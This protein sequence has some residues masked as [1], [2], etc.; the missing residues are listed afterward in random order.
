MSNPALD[1]INAH[2]DPAKSV[3]LNIRQWIFEQ[4]EYDQLPKIEETL[5]W[6]EPSY[7]VKGGSTIRIDFKQKNP[8]HVVIYLNCK[9]T[10]I[11]T[12]REVYSTEFKFEGNRAL[13]INLNTAIPEA[14]IK[15]CLSM[16][17]NY[18]KLK[19]QPLL[20]A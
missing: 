16:A 20:G 2:P 15:H 10:L 3:L 6:G 4:A 11:E 17:L 9:T 1:I 18:H 8:E 7:L 14:A 13:L 19:N 12:I 5:K